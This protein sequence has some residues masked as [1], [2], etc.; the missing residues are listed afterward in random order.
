MM[1]VFFNIVENIVGNGENA[2]YKHFVIFPQC[3]KKV[4]LWLL[5]VMIVW[6]RVNHMIA[7]KGLKTFWQKNK[8]YVISILSFY[9]Y[10][11]KS[12]LPKFLLTHYQTTN[13]RL[14]QIERLCRRQ[15]KI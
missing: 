4:F 3:F 15:F 13:F 5:N 1:A 9:K 8:M 10:D 2:D 12:C 7:L 6:Q 11:F 14:F